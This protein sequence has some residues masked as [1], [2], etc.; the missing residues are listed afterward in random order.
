MSR[1]DTMI[2]YIVLLCC[3]VLLV[4]DATITVGDKHYPSMPAVFGKPFSIVGDDDKAHLQILERNPFLCQ[5]PGLSSLN[6]RHLKR[7]GVE[8]NETNRIIVPT[9]GLPGK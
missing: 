1:I 4:V 6:E 5:G 2:G 3:F 9:D 8:K 7:H